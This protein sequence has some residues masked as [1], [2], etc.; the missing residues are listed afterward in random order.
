VGAQNDDPQYVR[1][2]E[3]CSTVCSA[4]KGRKEEREK[5]E[6]KLNDLKTLPPAEFI[7]W[8]PDGA[9]GHS[10]SCKYNSPS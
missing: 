3:Y 7:E 10:Q 5:N 2:Q 6:Q 1:R 8:M 9:L 4:S